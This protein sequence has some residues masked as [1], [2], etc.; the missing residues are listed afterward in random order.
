M[1]NALIV[2][3]FTS[4]DKYSIME[5]A[6]RTCPHSNAKV[7]EILKRTYHCYATINV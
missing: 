7:I 3:R 5:Y 1:Y 4:K 6:V 2:S